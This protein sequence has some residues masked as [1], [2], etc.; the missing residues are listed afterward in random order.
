MKKKG[1]KSKRFKGC[2][3][4]FINMITSLG[5]LQNSVI[6]PM[7]IR[8]NNETKNEPESIC[9][10][11]LNADSTEQLILPCNCSQGHVHFDCL[12]EW[13]RKRTDDN[14]H[15]CE[16]CNYPYRNIRFTF[17]SQVGNYILFIMWLF[18]LVGVFSMFIY[19]IMIFDKNDIN[20]NI[21]YGC[22]FIYVTCIFIFFST[23]SVP[24]TTVRNIY[25]I[26]N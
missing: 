23:F 20:F 15:T 25:R 22:L 10:I 14:F 1:L 19:T 3:F 9:R 12:A 11:C 13:I 4:F 8:N 6:N 2:I 7:Y 5:V 18:F 24:T 16:I 26:I 21:L 17:K